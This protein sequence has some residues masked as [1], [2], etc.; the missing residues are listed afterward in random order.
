[1]IIVGPGLKRRQRLLFCNHW[2]IWL[3]FRQRTARKVEVVQ[4]LFA[5]H[6]RTWLN[7]GLRFWLGSVSGQLTLRVELGTAFRSGDA[8]HLPVMGQLLPVSGEPS[9]AIR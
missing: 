9:F 5:S 7:H 3:I 8:L 6:G 1:M 4:S 2:R